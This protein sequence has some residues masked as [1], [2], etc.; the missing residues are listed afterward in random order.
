MHGGILG[1]TPQNR[2]DRI[3]P[4]CFYAYLSCSSARSSDPLAKR[5]FGV[6]EDH[7]HGVLAGSQDHALGHHAAQGSGSDERAQLQ[8]RYA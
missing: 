1:G 5:R 4:L 7:A 2:G 8:E 3:S 6:K